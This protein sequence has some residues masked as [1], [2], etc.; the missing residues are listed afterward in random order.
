MSAERMKKRM[1]D[2][3]AKAMDRAAGNYTNRRWFRRVLMLGIPLLLLIVAG[4]AVIVRRRWE[5]RKKTFLFPET[6][7]RNRF[8]GPW[9][10]GGNV[11]LRVTSKVGEDGSRRG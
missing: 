5:D 1:D 2:G 7:H 8:L 10:G 3:R 4:A 6:E 11:I 9:S